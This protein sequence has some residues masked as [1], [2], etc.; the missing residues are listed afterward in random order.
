MIAKIGELL[1]CMENFNKILTINYI[2]TKAGLIKDINQRP[3]IYHYNNVKSLVKA[4]IFSYSKK[5]N[6]T[7]NEK[8]IY[9]ISG[10]LHDVIEDIENGEDLINRLY[11]VDKLIP[12]ETIEIIKILTKQKNQKY[13]DYIQNI[14]NSN[15]KYAILVKIADIQDHLQTICLIQDINVRNRLLK[16]YNMEKTLIPLFKKYEEL[17]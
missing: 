14:I 13:L 15:N 17:I 2:I 3:I 12:F 4:L 6:F 1:S 16:K 7:K 9:E 5:Y 11:Y 8:D 10:Y